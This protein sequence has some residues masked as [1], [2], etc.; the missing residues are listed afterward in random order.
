[1]MLP[2]ARIAAKYGYYHNTGRQ[3]D[4]QATWRKTASLRDK[5]PR[6]VAINSYAPLAN[7]NGA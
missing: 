7:A 3:L 2:P 6:R 4:L 5:N 1:M